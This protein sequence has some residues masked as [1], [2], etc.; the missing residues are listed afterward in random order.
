VQVL[1]VAFLALVVFLFFI[2]SKRWL[3]VDA[4]H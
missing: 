4:R 2:L 1:L 3:F